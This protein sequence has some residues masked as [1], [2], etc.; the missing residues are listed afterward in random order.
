MGL[1][2][3]CHATDYDYAEVTMRGSAVLPTLRRR[4]VWRVDALAVRRPF[5][6]RMPRR[7]NMDATT[8]TN[9]TNA[10][11]GLRRSGGWS[12]FGFDMDDEGSLAQGLSWSDAE[13]LNTAAK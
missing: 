2:L 13:R 6:A 10:A 1:A 11:E 3:P 7:D 5:L 4:G 8:I 12:I 9:D